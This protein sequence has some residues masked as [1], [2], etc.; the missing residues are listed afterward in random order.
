MQLKGEVG[1][2]CGAR[3]VWVVH[4]NATVVFLYETTSQSKTF[5]LT[6]KI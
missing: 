1:L 3:C 6:P 5:A 4:I 2:S